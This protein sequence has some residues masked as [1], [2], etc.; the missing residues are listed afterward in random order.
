MPSRV[1]VIGKDDGFFSPHGFVV[2][3][4]PPSQQ[5]SVGNGGDDAVTMITDQA[6]ITILKIETTNLIDVETEMETRGHKTAN[7]AN[8]VYVKLNFGTI[9]NGQ[10]TVQD[11]A[12]ATATY[13]YQPDGKD[14]NEC[15]DMSYK[16]AWSSLTTDKLSVHVWDENKTHLHREIG[17]SRSSITMKSLPQNLPKDGEVIQIAMDLQHPTTKEGKARKEII[18]LAGKV[19]ITLRVTKAPL[20]YA[21]LQLRLYQ[22]ATTTTTLQPQQPPPLSSSGK[23]SSLEKKEKIEQKG[24]GDV[25]MGEVT[26]SIDELERKVLK[27]IHAAMYKK[28]PTI[29]ALKEGSK[30]GA[31]DG[32]KDSAIVATGLKG[33]VSKDPKQAQLATVTPSSTAILPKITVNLEIPLSPSALAVLQA[34]DQVES[35]QDDTISS[36]SKNVHHKVNFLDC[37]ITPPPSPTMIL[38]TLVGTKPTIEATKPSLERPL[39][40]KNVP[41]SSSTTRDNT[42]RRGSTDVSTSYIFPL[43]PSRVTILTFMS[44][45]FHT[46]LPVSSVSIYPLINA[47]TYPHLLHFYLS[48]HRSFCHRRPIKATSTYPR[49]QQSTTSRYWSA[50]PYVRFHP[51]AS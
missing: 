25:M 14:V 36:K 46:Y 32:A 23:T 43:P 12:G 10:T 50:H 6:M 37:S 29:P 15:F 39:T 22:T 2:S 16:T 19:V 51:T 35:N 31:K 30:D 13:D 5:Q 42:A 27:G 11:N 17:S 3:L 34:S 40:D 45:P 49:N 47:P 24:G 44:S 38:P 8:D 4:R 28:N 33:V 41:S 1:D 9:W 26:I 20:N 7:D 48:V 21:P 18:P